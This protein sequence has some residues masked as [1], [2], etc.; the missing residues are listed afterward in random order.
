MPGTLIKDCPWWKTGVVYQIYPA[1]YNDSNNDGIGDLQ[2]IIQKLDYIKALGVDIIWICPHFDSPQVDM[3]YDISDYQ[4]IYPPY[5]TVAD[6]EMLIAECHAR[7]LKIIFDLVV[8]HTSDQHKWFQESR[9]S[10]T[11]PKRDWYIWRP[12][13]YDE[14]GNRKPPNNWRSNFTGPAWTWDEH[15]QEYYLHLFAPEQ[16]DLNWENEEV[17]KSIYEDIMEFWLRKGVDGFRVDTVNMYC[18]GDMKDAPITQPGEETQFAGFSYCNGPRMHEYLRQMNEVLV[19]YDA[20][21]VGECPNTPDMEKVKK[22]VSAREKQ[23]NMVFQFDVVDVGSGQFKFQTVPF[24]WKLPDFKAAIGRTQSI[25]K[26]SDGWSTAFLENHDQARSVSRFA[27]DAPEFR[28]ASAR[29]LALMLITLSG[30]LF[31]YQGQELGMVNAPLSW[32]MDEYKDLDSTNYYEMVRRNTNGD[33]KALKEAK[34]A[35]QYLAR[36]HARMPMQWDSSP[37]AGFSKAQPWMR[38]NDDPHCNAAAQEKDPK[39]VLAFWRNMLKLRKQ[40]VELFVLGEYQALDFD[41]PNTFTYTKTYNGE[42]ALIVLNFS[43]REQS[44]SALL[45]EFKPAKLLISSEQEAAGGS[46]VPYEGRVYIKQQVQN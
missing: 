45:S 27:S 22:Y 40:H 43:K 10:K 20:M 30:T 17:R 35:L 31:V 42:E 11:N 6:C 34:E 21:S 25:M 37:N 33:P 44:I 29:M 3:G 19:K 36:D 28:E 16:P 9:L 38:V 1:S 24:N 12:A 18:K 23:L 13:R 7:G 8:N 4:S 26:D 2:G 5:G 41:N 46:L 15:T 32:P 39:S 14:K